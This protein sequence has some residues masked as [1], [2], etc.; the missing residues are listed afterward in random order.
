MRNISIPSPANYTEFL[1]DYLKSNNLPNTLSELD[2]VFECDFKE[3][4]KQYYLMREIGFTT[5][6]LFKQKLNI[7]CNIMIPFY[8]EKALMYKEAFNNIFENGYSISQTNNL[9]QS[10]SS[11]LSRDFTNTKNLTETTNDNDSVSHIDYKTPI[12][13]SEILPN[14]A[15]SGGY[16]DN[17][18]KV[19][20][21]RANTGTD[22]VDEET[23]QTASQT[24]TG[25]I[26][27]IYSKNPRYNSLEALTKMRE[28][29]LNI[30]KEALDAFDCLFMQVF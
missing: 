24:N 18:T 14:S 21:T 13:Q 28:E 6:E 1:R 11:S 5:E 29:F 12:S 26:T 23:T 19:N 25:T 2:S 3:E 16:K 4:F 30:K 20:A 8:K 10:N 17:K 9:A 27:T 22:V 15:I 7:Q